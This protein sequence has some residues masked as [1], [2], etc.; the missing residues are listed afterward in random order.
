MSLRPLRGLFACLV[1]LTAAFA[2]T[3]APLRVQGSYQSLAPHLGVRHD[4][5]GSLTIQAVH[6]TGSTG[7]QP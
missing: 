7:F 6:A 1:F 4:P 5:E 3:A 2:E